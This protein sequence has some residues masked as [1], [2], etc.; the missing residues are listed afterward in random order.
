MQFISL[1]YKKIMKKTFW[2]IKLINIYILLAQLYILHDSVIA[3]NE[4]ELF[5]PYFSDIY[6]LYDPKNY[7]FKGQHHI[8]P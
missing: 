8:R 3:Y 1:K 7:L 5:F 4:L 6:D 2:M